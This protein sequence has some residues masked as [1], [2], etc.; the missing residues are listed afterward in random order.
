M[1]RQLRRANE[2][3]DKRREREQERRKTERRAARVVSTPSKTA[4]GKQ[5][6]SDAPDKPPS[7]PAPGT[8]RQGLSLAY[9]VLTVGIIIAQAFVPQQT[10]PFSL[11][12]HA[13]FYVILGYFLCLWLFRRGV[14]Q[15]FV[16]T[17][18]SGTLLSAAVEVA[19]LVT[20]PAAPEPLFVY[21]SL[22]GLLAGAWLGR[23]VYQQ[24]AR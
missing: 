10:D 2:K 9:L 11:V 15:A 19:K 13:L 17:L 18:V 20:S 4:A 12:I 8:R 21:L 7:R 3:S 6:G 14:A 5:S 1:N 23:F 22:P 24:N 16:I